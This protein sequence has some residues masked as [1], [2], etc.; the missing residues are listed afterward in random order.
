MADIA[1]A[2]VDPGARCSSIALGPTDVVSVALDESTC[3]AAVAGMI[4]MMFPFLSHKKRNLL[5]AT[6]GLIVCMTDPPLQKE[7]MWSS[8]TQTHPNTSGLEATGKCWNLQ[9]GQ[10]HQILTMQALVFL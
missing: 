8:M 9:P 10:V 6:A 2:R 5:V 7:R 3:Y 4:P 1:N